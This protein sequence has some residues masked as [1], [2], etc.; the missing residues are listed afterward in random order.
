M[1]TNYR[2]PPQ[3]SSPC[4]HCSDEGLHIGKN[5]WGWVFGFQAYPELGLV[6]WQAWRE[7]I[8]KLNHVID[9]YGVHMP[10]T[11]FIELV[12]RTREPYGPNRL[13]PHRRDGVSPI[14]HKVDE[15]FFVST[16]DWDFW[17]GDFS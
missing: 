4:S 2:T 14:L 12:E 10:T 9:E 8:A 17:D 1:G 7:H 11:E 13:Q 5:S 16:D 15:R 6:S 3:C